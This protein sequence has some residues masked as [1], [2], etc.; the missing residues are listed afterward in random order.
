MGEPDGVRTSKYSRH[1]LDT[2][3]LLL[4]KFIVFKR[5]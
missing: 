1:S 3:D 5:N 2:V 4:S